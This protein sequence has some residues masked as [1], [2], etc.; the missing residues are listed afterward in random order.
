ML[1]PMRLSIVT[2]VCLVAAP[3]LFVVTN[4]L[5]PKEYTLDHE[6]QQIGA[7][8]D[9]YHR[10]QW[11]H[12]LTF[13]V[14]L[15]FAVAIAG[16]GAYTYAAS[17]RLAVAGVA[18]GIAGSIGLGGVLAIDGFSWGILG[19]VATQPG[20]DPHTL[21]LVLRNMQH[22]E[23][24]LTF[25]AMAAAWISGLLCLAVGLSRA[26]LVPGWAAGLFGLGVA[27]VGIEGLVHDNVYFVVAAVVLTF[28]AIAVAVSLPGDVAADVPA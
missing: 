16:L 24:G 22:S 20:A 23:F 27:L 14:I 9:A 13:V 25:Y 15:L 19:T 7:I 1:S 26:R 3:A 6:A 17:P 11:A 12:V 4:L 5:H 21:Q 18:L 10:W 2:K 8:A 28:G